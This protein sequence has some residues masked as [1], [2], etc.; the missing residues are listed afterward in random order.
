MKNLFI[1]CLIVLASTK[2]I[3]IAIIGTNDIHGTAFPMEMIR[4]D[5]KEIYFY[6]GL[7]VMG[8]LI[9]IIKK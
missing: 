3:T 9:N 1:L 4:S 8:G 7:N 5:T 6:G 2:N